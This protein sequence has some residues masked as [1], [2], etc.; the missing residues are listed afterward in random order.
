MNERWPDQRGI[1]HVR[2][3]LGV[4]NCQISM[5]GRP[6]PVRQI[7]IPNR[8]GHPALR[9]GYPNPIP[10]PIKKIA[11]IL[12]TI[13]TTSL[14]AMDSNNNQSMESIKTR[15]PICNGEVNKSRPSDREV[16][17]NVLCQ[18]EYYVH[19]KDVNGLD[20]LNKHTEAHVNAPEKRFAI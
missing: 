19:Y 1:R 4:L 10:T 16:K 8:P 5:P 2:C 17:S 14:F 9:G 15:C 11:S 7:P 6:L 3:E 20:V 12:R 18:N 13:Y